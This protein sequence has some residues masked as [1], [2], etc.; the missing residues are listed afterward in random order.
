M[1]LLKI[2][3]NNNYEYQLWKI[4]DDLT[5]IDSLYDFFQNYHPNIYSYKSHFRINQILHTKRI[6]KKMVGN[7]IELVQ[8]ANGK[9][10]LTGSNKYISITNHKNY[11]A[12]MIA[13]FICG[14]DLESTKRNYLKIQHKFSHTKDFVSKDNSDLALVWCSKEVLYKSIGTPLISFKKNLFINK[15]N[16][17]LIGSCVHDSISFRAN[18]ALIKIKDLLLVY[19]LNFQRKTLDD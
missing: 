12:V 3:K 14:I 6:V 18:L 8:D 19:N 10:H 17:E 7:N 16:E 13:N 9:P 4:D 1:G 5:K 2:H 15:N 11:I